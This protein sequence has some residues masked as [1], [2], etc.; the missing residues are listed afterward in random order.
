MCASI[1]MICLTIKEN[2]KSISNMKKRMKIANAISAKKRIQIKTIS[3]GTKKR[4][5]QRRKNVGMSKIFL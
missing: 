5:T 1:V 2:I 3:K 4:S